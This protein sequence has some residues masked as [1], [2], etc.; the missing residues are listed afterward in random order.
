MDKRID[1]IATAIKSGLKVTELQELEF[2]YA[3]PF[4]SAK[5]IVNL[6]GYVS[7][8]V[9]LG[10]SKTVQWHQV[11]A[12][13]E[14][15]A[16]FVDVRNSSEVRSLGKIKGALNI[17]IDELRSRLDEIPKDKKIVLYCQSGTRS[18]NAEQILRPLGYDCYNLDGSYSIYSNTQKEVK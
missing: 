18:Y 6:A 10:L 11:D 3:P 17:P 4:G 14:E 2:T 7:Q 15:G 16:F 1:I 13:I 8:N 9:I 12:L 5:D